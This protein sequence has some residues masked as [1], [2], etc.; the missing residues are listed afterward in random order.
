MGA[1][2]GGSAA[3]DIRERLLAER[4]HRAPLVALGGVQLAPAL[5]NHGDVGRPVGALG[6]SRISAPGDEFAANFGQQVLILDVPVTGTNYVYATNN[7]T[8]TTLS[9]DPPLK[10]IS[11]DTIWRFP[12]GRVFTNSVATYRAPDA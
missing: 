11:V 9:T 10:M 6:R 4:F 12:R 5:D 3:H 1:G 8:I 2:G 7:T